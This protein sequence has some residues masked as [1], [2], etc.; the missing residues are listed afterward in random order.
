MTRNLWARSVVAAVMILC[1]LAVGI[2]AARLRPDSAPPAERTHLT[3]EVVSVTRGDLTR[4]TTVTGN[5]IPAST[6]T[7]TPKV[8]GRIESMPVELGQHVLSGDLILKLET[9]ELE[10]AVAQAQGALDAASANHARLVRGASQQE[11]DQVEA[12]LAQAQAAYVA[13]QQSFARAERLYAEGAVSRQQFEAAETQLKVASAQL[14]MAERQLELVQAGPSA[15]TLA[16][17]SAT[18]T[19][20]QAAYDLA[21]ARLADAVLVSP[22]TGYVAHTGAVPGELVSPGVP[23]AVIVDLDRVYVE[24]GLPESLVTRVS[25]GDTLPV[26]VRAVSTAPLAG[27]VTH[28]APAADSR[29]RLFRVKVRLDN[30]QLILKPGMVAELELCV[31]AVRNGLLVPRT[32]ILSKGATDYVFVVADGIARRRRVELGLMDAGQAEIISGLNEGELVVV[33]SASY[34]ADGVPVNTRSGVR[35]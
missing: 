12:A 2:A 17:A 22:L 30:P 5:L 26:R 9:R 34:L 29:T 10:I 13:A 32:A 1:A 20:A 3:V 18:V 19:Q 28:L 6:V 16:A 8:A 31:G 27:T 21:R 14:T 15:E 4:V 24:A 35:P 25:V 23:V 11:I 33:S 7:L